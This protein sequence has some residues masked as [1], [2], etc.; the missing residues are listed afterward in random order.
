MSVT[1]EYQRQWIKNNPEKV[2]AYRKRDEERRRENKARLAFLKAERGC[3]DCGVMGL[4][5]EA[6]EFHHTGQKEFAVGHNLHKR[7]WEDTMKEI[8][9]CVCLCAN[10][11]RA[12]HVKEGMGI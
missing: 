8:E 9:K 6:Y 4:P 11:H 7:S 3:Y 2:Q 5:A 12:R 10:C 1:L